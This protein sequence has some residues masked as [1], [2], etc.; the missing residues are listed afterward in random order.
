MKI[1]VL[2]KQNI[3]NIEDKNRILNDLKKESSFQLVECA[4]VHEINSEFDRILVFGGD[5]TMLEAVSKASK[6]NIPILGVNLGNLGFLAK[7]EQ[8]ADPKKIIKAL[9]SKRILNRFLLETKISYK[10]SAECYFAL[11][12][13]V[14]KSVSTRPVYLNLKIDDVYVDTYHSDG[15]IISTPT[16]STA[17]SLSAGGPV[18][19]PKVDAVVI[20]PVC[21]HSLHSRPLVIN[22]DAEIEIEITNDVETALVVDGKFI[23]NIN[24]VHNSICI[25]KSKKTAKFIA[26]NGNNFYKKL[27][28]KMNRWG[29]TSQ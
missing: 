16:G 1:A 20:N 29:T 21:P 13:V 23:G 22:S 4:S 15:I 17:Y 27:L 18:L 10:D 8:H 3:K 25:N 9:K 5:G 6:Y 28:E 12:E 24:N 2:T 14:I 26:I 7:F 11:N 19:S